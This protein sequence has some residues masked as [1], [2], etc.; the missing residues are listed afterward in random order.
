VSAGSAE[1]GN[2]RS[3]YEDGIISHANRT[4]RDAGVQPGMSLRFVAD[5]LAA[6][7]GSV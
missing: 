7:G 6:N 3:S 5:R 2:A 1:I 4:A